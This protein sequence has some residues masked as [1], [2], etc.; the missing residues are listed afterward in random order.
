[1]RTIRRYTAIT[2]R[3]TGGRYR[4]GIVTAVA[5]QNQVTARIG[6]A[7]SGATITANRTNST[8]TRGKEWVQA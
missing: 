6:L 2:I 7:G 5:N 3:T 4:H 8:T 1:M